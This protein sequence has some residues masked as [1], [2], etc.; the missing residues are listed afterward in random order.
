MEDRHSFSEPRPIPGLPLPTWEIDVFRE[1][2]D[3]PIESL[4]ID[5]TTL[6]P[7]RR[8]GKVVWKLP[9]SVETL[10]KFGRD[11]TLRLLEIFKQQKK[12]RRKT[13]KNLGKHQQ[14]SEDSPN[15]ETEPSD[16]GTPSTSEPKDENV[17]TSGTEIDISK[18]KSNGNIST[19][20]SDD[21]HGGGGADQSSP[22]PVHQQTE[23]EPTTSSSH[24]AISNEVTPI[25]KTPAAPPPGFEP[26]SIPS[27]SAE[28]PLPQRYFSIPAFDSTITSA[29]VELAKCFMDTFYPMIT[30][31]LHDELLL[32]Y[33]PQ[34]QK[35]LSAGGAHA[36]CASRHE[37]SV[38]LQS[39]SESHWDV[40]G[41]VA[42]QG[43][44]GSVV[45]L[46]TGTMLAKNSSQP[47]TFCHTVTLTRI[48]DVYQIHNDALA[49]LMDGTAVT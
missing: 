20:T 48:K 21:E 18:R 49:L 34:A 29:P 27:S 9:D 47:F 22:P 15:E 6:P 25:L 42:Q 8:K 10:P 30:Q 33:A 12:N 4:R 16:L 11:E 19:G 3:T 44:M 5:E 1:N 37:I 7:R 2:V 24:A 32:Y 38:Q 41:V 13:K 46:I 43:I 17:E 35:S 23:T 26:S 36:F 40:R 28:E 39:L 14:A 31:G 45:L